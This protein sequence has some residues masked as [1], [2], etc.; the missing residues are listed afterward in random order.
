VVLAVQ[1][2]VVLVVVT[3]TAQAQALTQRAV[4]AVLVRHLFLLAVQAV[5]VLLT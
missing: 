1:V 4:V 3:Q 5:A 2:L